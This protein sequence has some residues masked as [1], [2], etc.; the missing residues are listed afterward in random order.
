MAKFVINPKLK[1]QTFNISVTRP[2]VHVS[3]GDVV[4][5]VHVGVQDGVTLLHGRVAHDAQLRYERLRLVVLAEVRV[6]REHGDV[7]G[8]AVG[9]EDLKVEL[10]VVGE[11]GRG[12]L[13][14]LGQVQQ[15]VLGRGLLVP[16]VKL[17]E[18]ERLHRDLAR[19]EAPVDVAQPD[20][21]VAQLGRQVSGFVI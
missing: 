15:V 20:R 16:A 5:L 1:A 3:L 17:V 13:P 14:E 8:H 6:P 7:A 12:A 21:K 19:Q 2:L 11:R 9:A 18:R 4:Q 10:A